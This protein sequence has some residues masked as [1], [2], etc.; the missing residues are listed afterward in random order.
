METKLGRAKGKGLKQ[1]ATLH[2]GAGKAPHSADPANRTLHLLLD[3]I[4]C[5][6]SLDVLAHAITGE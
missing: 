4:L 5:R 2:L 3:S 1:S 6:L